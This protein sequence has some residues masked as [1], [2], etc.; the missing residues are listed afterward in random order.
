MQYKCAIKELDNHGF[1]CCRSIMWQHDCR[2]DHVAAVVEDHRY[3]ALPWKFGKR[4][5]AIAPLHAAYHDWPTRGKRRDAATDQ[6]E[7][8]HAIEILVICDTGGAITGTQFRTEIDVYFAAAVRGL[9]GERLAC[10]P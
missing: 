3:R 8:T 10:S 2:N 4:V 6:I 1:D 7:V 5:S 9:A